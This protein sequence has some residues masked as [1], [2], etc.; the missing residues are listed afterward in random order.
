MGRGGARG[1]A[2]QGEGRFGVGSEQ[3]QCHTAVSVRLHLKAQALAYFPAIR[4][5]HANL[6]PAQQERELLALGLHRGLHDLAV[7]E[8][9]RTSRDRLDQRH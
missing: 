4:A 3:L 9:Q 8:L 1:V 7:F 5:R 6:S 2:G